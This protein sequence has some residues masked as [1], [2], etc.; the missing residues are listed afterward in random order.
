VVDTG[1]SWLWAYTDN[2]KIDDTATVCS[3]TSSL[4]HR[5]SSTTFKS[6]AEPKTVVYGS[7]ELNGI[8]AQEDITFGRQLTAT[9]MQI[10]YEDRTNSASTKGILGLAPKSADKGPLFVDNLV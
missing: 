5:V 7:L 3:A 10:L 6:T 2:C 9:G 4:F 1:S 8:L